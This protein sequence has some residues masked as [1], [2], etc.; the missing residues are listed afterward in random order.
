MFLKSRKFLYSWY[1]LEDFRDFRGNGH[2]AH[3]QH[4]GSCAITLAEVGYD[5]RYKTKNVK[6]TK[7]VSRKKFFSMTF[8]FWKSKKFREI[9]KIFER[10]KWSKKVTF[11][12]FQLCS[13]IFFSSKKMKFCWKITFY[14]YRISCPTPANSV[15][16]L[17]LCRPWG[18]GKR[19]RKS[20]KKTK[21]FHVFLT[22]Y[23]FLDILDTT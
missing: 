14:F 11:S 18:G 23:T 19:L 6:K 10:K 2:R 3:G 22:N 4:R 1:N 5:I 17:P 9:F 20:G 21:K 15:A 12:I 13:K 7:N 16:Q 8:F